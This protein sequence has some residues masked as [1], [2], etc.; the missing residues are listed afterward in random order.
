[1][2]AS[3]P[4]SILLEETRKVSDFSFKTTTDQ[5]SD[6]LTVERKPTVG[7]CSLEQQEKKGFGITKE[8]SFSSSG[9]INKGLR[10]PSRRLSPGLSWRRSRERMEVKFE[11]FSSSSQFIEQ[12]R[13][14][15]L[16]RLEEAFNKLLQDKTRTVKLS[17][18]SREGNSVIKK[19]SKWTV[20]TASSRPSDSCCESSCSELG[21]REQYNKHYV[22]QVKPSLPQTGYFTGKKWVYP[23]DISLYN[24]CVSKRNGSRFHV[25]KP[26]VQ[27]FNVRDMF[28]QGTGKPLNTSCNKTWSVPRQ[29]TACKSAPSNSQRIGKKLTSPTFTRTSA[30][31]DTPM[32]AASQSEP[33]NFMDFKSLIEGQSVTKLLPKS[34]N[35]FEH[36]K[37]VGKT[38][39]YGVENKVQ[40]GLEYE[41]M[42]K[43]VID[44]YKHRK[45]DTRSVRIGT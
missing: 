36:L 21:Q 38:V 1:M 2:E 6:W 11:H 19:E 20:E 18:S 43:D 4:E 30:S 39:E 12:Y 42:F 45:P 15:K 14:A 17:E 32:V 8:Q 23:K 25:Q 33:T 28:L 3:T 5:F 31:Q 27:V 13:N 44:F 41:N 26:E 10:L 35:S 16:I 29:R 37:K 7:V 9:N 22:D 24:S 34:Y 40:Q